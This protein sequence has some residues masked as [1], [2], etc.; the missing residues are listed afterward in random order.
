[1]ATLVGSSRGVGDA[2][3]AAVG[4][5]GDNVVVVMYGLINTSR[6]P[7]PV[8]CL[9][10]EAATGRLLVTNTHTHTHTHTMQRILEQRH[11]SNSPAVARTP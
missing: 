11:D 9:R 7:D 10:F 2:V 3:G 5:V 8:A 6:L 1:M 4:A